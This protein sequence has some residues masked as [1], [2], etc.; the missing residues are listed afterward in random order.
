MLRWFNRSI[1]VVILIAVVMVGGM[2]QAQEETAECFFVLPNQAPISQKFQSLDGCVNVLLMRARDH[3]LADASGHWGALT[4]Y[5]NSTGDVSYMNDI[6]EWILLRSVDVQNIENVNALP[7]GSLPDFTAPNSLTLEQVLDLGHQDVGTFWGELMSGSDYVA[8]NVI[9]MTE[10]YMETACGTMFEFLGPA[11][12][13]LDNTIYLPYSFMAAE[14]TYVG[15]FSIVL[16]MAHE[17]AHSLQL[18]L[19]IESATV[20]EHELQADCLAGGYAAYLVAESQILALDEGDIEEGAVSLFLAGDDLPWFDPRSHGTGLER[21]A[22]FNLG[23]ENG[24][25]A[26][27]EASFR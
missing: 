21:V 15:D 16:I 10:L 3:G 14:Y 25:A 19:N 23:M 24:W 8:P 12:C 6:G 7:D 9:V 27:F 18:Q 22:A 17:W 2:S 11:F 4:I 1:I 20:R 26:C 13:R 5:V